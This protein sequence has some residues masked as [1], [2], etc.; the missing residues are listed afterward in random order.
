MPTFSSY[1]THDIKEVINRIWGKMYT[2]VGELDITAW[3]TPEP[4][5]FTHRT[6]GKKIKLNLGDSWGKNLFDC[7]WFNF[8][9]KIPG[10]CKNRKVVALIDINGEL[11]IF[12]KKGVPVR[13]LTN[14]SSVF[15][16]TYGKPLKR[17]YEITQKATG[18]EAVD[19]WA[20]AGCND[21]LGMRQHNCKIV[22]THLAICNEQTRGLYYDME[23]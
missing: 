4:V 14:A 3:V 18:G 11:C 22:N 13:G 7:A 23:V 2:T 5:A 21:L 19:I 15:D 8:K 10:G 1:M 9:G 16:R 12:D 6:Q 20:D 17:V